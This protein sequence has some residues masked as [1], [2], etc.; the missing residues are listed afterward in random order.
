MPKKKSMNPKIEAMLLESANQA[1]AIEKS[2]LQG[3]VTNPETV[4]LSKNRD[5]ILK[6]PV[7]GMV[8]DT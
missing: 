2:E 6:N 5:E 8:G 3:R 4:L 1:F 7:P